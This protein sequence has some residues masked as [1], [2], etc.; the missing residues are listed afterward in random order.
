MSKLWKETTFRFELSEPARIGVYVF[1]LTG[2]LVWKQEDDLSIGQVIW[3]G[4][5]AKGAIVGN[6]VYLVAIVNL[7]DNK[8]IGRCKPFVA[9]SN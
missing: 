2:K 3:D 7:D 5:D 8:L 4:R 1:N 6:G 9:K